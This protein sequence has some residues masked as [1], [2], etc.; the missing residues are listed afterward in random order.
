MKIFRA[1]IIWACALPISFIGVF[2][3]LATITLWGF[4]PGEPASGMTWDEFQQ[5]K[6]AHHDGFPLSEII[7]L[8]LGLITTIFPIASAFIL[9]RRKSTIGSNKA[10]QAIGTKV[11]QPER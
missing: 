2:L 7:M 5:L 11:P 6:D 3:T 10:F 1:I 4:G 9:T 8:M